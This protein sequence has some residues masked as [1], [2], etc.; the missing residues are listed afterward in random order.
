MNVF[1]DELKT[2]GYFY[3]N[4]VSSLKQIREA[5][6][7]RLKHVLQMTEMRRGLK[8][9]SSYVSLIPI[10]KPISS[11]K[12]FTCECSHQKSTTRQS[13]SLCGF[14]Y[15]SLAPHTISPFAF[16]ILGNKWVFWRT[17]VKITKL[18]GHVLIDK[19]IA[20]YM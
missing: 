12:W 13:F 7:T 1:R 20:Y 17:A 14:S 16:F 8:R 9:P 3:V 2:L 11:S 15:L 10:S 19:T 18:A 5:R 6:L 4:V